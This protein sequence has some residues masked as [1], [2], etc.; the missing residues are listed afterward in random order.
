MRAFAARLRSVRGST[1]LDPR[2]GLVGL[3][4]TGGA[5]ANAGKSS[6]ASLHDCGAASKEL[7]VLG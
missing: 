5:R 2:A 4:R 1:L 6:A 7:R 3:G